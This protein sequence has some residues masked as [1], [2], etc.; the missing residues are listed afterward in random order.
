MVLQHRLWAAIRKAPKGAAQVFEPYLPFTLTIFAVA[1]L[2]F[3]FSAMNAGKST[4][5]L[6][7]SHNYRERGLHTRLLTAALDDRYGLGRITSRIGLHAEAQAFRPDDDLFAQLSKQHDDT[8][9]SC[10]L[11]DE[12]QFLSEAQ[13]WQLTEVVDQL[14]IPVMAYGLRTDFQGR[15]FEGARALLAWAD[16]IKEIKTICHC[17]RKATMVVRVSEEGKVLT[18]GSQVEV[19]GNERYVSLCRRHW[20][21]SFAPGTPR[22]SDALHKQ[23]ALDV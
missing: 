7:A 17:G 3:H 12:A 6:Q 10:V 20:K 8:A 4:L 13:V 1:K 19:G 14:G 2:Y 11:I 16:L 5:L 23:Y 21:Q 15:L 9:I 18:E 22:P